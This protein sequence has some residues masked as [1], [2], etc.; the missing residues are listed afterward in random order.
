MRKTFFTIGATGAGASLLSSQT[1][2]HD[3]DRA[4]VDERLKKTEGLYELVRKGTHASEAG[5][6]ERKYA[7]VQK[8][9]EKKGRNMSHQEALDTI[10]HQLG[11]DQHAQLSE[12]IQNGAK[13]NGTNQYVTA[14]KSLNEMFLSVDDAKITTQTECVVTLTQRFK[15]L[16]VYTDTIRNFEMEIAEA[17]TQAYLSNQQKEVTEGDIDKKN[18]EADDL[19]AKQATEMGGENKELEGMEAEVSTFRFIM[20]QV[21]KQCPESTG[22]RRDKIN[23][24]KS[25]IDLNQKSRSLLTS[26]ADREQEKAREKCV[27]EGSSKASTNAALLKIFSDPK[28]AAAADKELDATSAHSLKQTIANIEAAE[29]EEIH[30]VYKGELSFL[31]KAKKSQGPDNDVAGAAAAAGGT[32]SRDPMGESAEGQLVA[33]MAGGKSDL[34]DLG[35]GCGN[36]DLDCDGLYTIVGQELECRKNKQKN[37][38]SYIKKLT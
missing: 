3:A 28:V 4:K 24:E 25:I 17:S 6:F 36:V 35:C 26:A 2:Q 21:E 32:S 5:E 34:F 9:A 13:A 33:S 38:E 22:S 8:A 23:G 14:M 11:S 29:R 1:V 15:Q 10:K 7:D 31:Q 27:S 16:G 37:Q 18:T 12:L 20:N 19:A 30:S